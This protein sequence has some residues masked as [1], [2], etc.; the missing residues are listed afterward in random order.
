MG[1]IRIY[2]LE[3]N[4]WV[5]KPQLDFGYTVVGK[6][7]VSK[8]LRFS[9]SEGTIADLKGMVEGNNDFI[10]I[11]SEKYLTNEWKSISPFKIKAG[12]MSDPVNIEFMVKSGPVRMDSIKMSF[13]Y[14]EIPG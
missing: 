8:T 10:F 4:D 12:E 5:E 1:K 2:E 3:G 13:E 11:K 7:F 14:L 9:P 6:S